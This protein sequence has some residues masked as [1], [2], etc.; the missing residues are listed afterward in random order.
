MWSTSA[1]LISE[2][3][4]GAV[5]DERQ[6]SACRCGQDPRLVPRPLENPGAL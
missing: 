1:A 3:A 2:A 6:G 4:A 5:Q